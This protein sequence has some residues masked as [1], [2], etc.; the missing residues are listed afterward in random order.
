MPNPKL[1]VKA[2]YLRKAGTDA[3]K[4]LWGELRNENLGVKFRRQH[5]IGRFILDFYAPKIRLAIELD[6]KQHKEMRDYDKLRAKYLKS[7]KIT[8]LRFWNFEVENDLGKVVN[9][10]KQTLSI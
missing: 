5:P 8:L 9:E 3:E 10:I 1:L 2:R 4:I 7:K 6:G